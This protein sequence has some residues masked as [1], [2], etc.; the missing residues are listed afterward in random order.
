VREAQSRLVSL[1]AG[2]ILDVAPDQAVH[3]A[4]AAGWPAVGI[5]FDPTTW[6]DVTT[7]M[8][9]TA[10]A[11]HALVALDV[12]PV[13][14]APDGPVVTDDGR[15]L[16]DAAVA[17]DARHVLVASRDPDHGRVAAAVSG[18]CE[19]ADGSDVR[20]VL[21]FLPIM[22]VRTLADAVD[23]V[24]TAGH[25][26]AGVLVDALHLVRSGGTPTDV[27]AVDPALLPYAQ[28]CDVDAIAP[29][30]LAGLL[31]EALHGRLL[32]GDGV[33]PLDELLAALPVRCPISV[34]MRSRELM[35]RFPDAIDRARAVLDS[36][37]QL[38][39]VGRPGTHP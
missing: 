28:W 16:V 4:A 11:E 1:A 2:T 19:R 21:E 10:L 18:L 5:W 31:D 34:E 20:V 38:P 6:T 25:P 30:D 27:A 22:A 36:V 9:A 7:R 33:A 35:T 3:V 12:E 26:A 37:R 24:A 15:R 8:V 17:L 23:I 32:P 39:D 14:L 13:L 29:T